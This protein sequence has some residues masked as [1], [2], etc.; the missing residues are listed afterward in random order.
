MFR[1][2]LMLCCF[3]LLVAAC[4][5]QSNEATLP[6]PSA[7]AVPT[8]TPSPT[9]HDTAVLHGDWVGSITIGNQKPLQMEL[10]IT[11][12]EDE[13]LADV[14]DF[15]FHNALTQEVPLIVQPENGTL[16]FEVDFRNTGQTTFQAFTDG[17]YMAGELLHEDQPGSFALTRKAVLDDLDPFIGT[18]RFSPERVVTI[19]RSPADHGPGGLFLP[20]LWFTDFGNGDYRTL[21]PITENSFLVGQALGLSAPGTAVITFST[22]REMMTWQA[23]DSHTNKRIGTE[24]TAVRQQFPTEEIQFASEDGTILAGTITFPLVD[25]PHPAIVLVHGSGRTERH[26]LSRLTNFLASTGFAVLA[27]DKRG[28]GAS[29]GAYSEQASE[30]NLLRL[31]ADAASG[32]AYLQTDPKIKPD[33]IGLYG[34]SQA[35]WIIPA[36]ANLS[37]Q[38]A[39]MVI[40][41]GPVVTTHQ[42]SIYSGIF[43]DGATIPTLTD[44]EI[45][46]RVRNATPAGFDPQP[47]IAQL[48][49]PGLWLFGGR[50][51]SVPVRVSAENLQAIIDEQGKENFSYLTFPTGDHG[52]WESATGSYADFPTIQRTVPG[53]HSTIHKWLV[54][55][56]SE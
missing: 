46:D 55:V 15:N 7:T 43:G 29:G 41:S 2:S 40:L 48:N 10:T 1:L 19:T 25:G 56:V 17:A 12:G 49:I 45:D 35:G 50:D 54:D 23:L 30:E 31:A 11:E 37:D 21:T 33:Q 9:L 18:Y 26:H 6:P 24:E 8:E 53:L 28:V 51:A 32:V 4:G 44:A 36:A 13:L 22:D 38:I 34:A 42:E 47:Y 52:L 14:A 16:Q 5:T 3:V 39:F 20:G 27:Y